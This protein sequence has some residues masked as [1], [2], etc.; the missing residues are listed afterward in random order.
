M[1][2]DELMPSTMTGLT[3]ASPSRRADG[4]PTGNVNF[5]DGA[6][7]LG[8]SP[9][10]ALDANPSDFML[11]PAAP[12]PQGKNLIRVQQLPR[13]PAKHACGKCE[14]NERTSAN[15]TAACVRT[16]TRFMPWSTAA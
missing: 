16:S 10:T 3:Y 2:R 15:T 14:G 4:A 5:M 1:L 8:T 13:T 12:L 9:P 7:L 11:S 6:K